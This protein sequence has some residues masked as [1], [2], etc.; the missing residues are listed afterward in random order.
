MR[1]KIV[2]FILLNVLFLKTLSDL[3][4]PDFSKQWA[5]YNN[6]ICNNISIDGEFCSINE[7]KK[8]IDIDAIKMWEIFN[9]KEYSDKKVIVAVIDTGVDYNHIDLKK[10]VDK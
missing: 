5:L 4:E 8:G 2:L 10:N 1:H 3:K 9:A 7:F 6:G